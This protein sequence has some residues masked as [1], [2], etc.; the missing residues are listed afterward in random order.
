MKKGRR[1]DP[2]SMWFRLRMVVPGTGVDIKGPRAKLKVAGLVVN[3]S[4]NIATGDTPIRRGRA[5][6]ATHQQAFGR[7]ESNIRADGQLGFDLGGTGD[8]DGHPNA[9]IRVGPIGGE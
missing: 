7:D 5:L 8:R 1:G 2:Y 3:A 9:R 6:G 4:C